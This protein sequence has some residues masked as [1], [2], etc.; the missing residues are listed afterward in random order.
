MGAE[1]I[2]GELFKLNIQVAKRTIQKYLL[3]VRSKP[4]S[5]QS[6]STFRKAD[7]KDIWAR[8][9]VPV[10]SAGGLLPAPQGAIGYSTA[11]ATS[12]G[13][14]PWGSMAKARSRRAVNCAAVALWRLRPVMAQHRTFFF[15]DCSGL[16]SKGTGLM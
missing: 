1:R 13:C 15:R 2:R 14:C 8:D 3:A 5:G 6:W 10:G 4:P 12:P 7:G 16:S 9:F 11:A